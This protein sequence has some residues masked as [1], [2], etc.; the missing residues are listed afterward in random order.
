MENSI[1]QKSTFSSSVSRVEHSCHYLQQMKNQIV[2]VVRTKLNE[3][4]TADYQLSVKNSAHE[5]DLKQLKSSI[6]SD[7][8]K[9]IGNHNT[10]H[11]L[12]TLKSQL[13]SSNS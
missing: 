12:M 10:I 11:S 13:L 5:R 9:K 1:L 4:K 2:N 3:R 8:K 7:K 6:H